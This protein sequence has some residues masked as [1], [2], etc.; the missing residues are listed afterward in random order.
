M[1][2]DSRLVTE[3]FL[4]LNFSPKTGITAGTNDLLSMDCDQIQARYNVSVLGITTTGR[5]CPSQ[6]QISALIQITPD[7]R[8]KIIFDSSG[9]M[10]STL[11]SLND[12]RSGNLKTALLPMYNNDSALYD[13]MVTVESQGIE[14]TFFMLNNNQTG[15]PSG[16]MIIIIFQNEAASLYH[17][18]FVPDPPFSL[19]LSQISGLRSSL[20]S[21]AADYYRGIVFQVSPGVFFSNNEDVFKPFLQAVKSN[22]GGYAGTN[23]LADKPEIAFEYDVLPGISYA[24]D[25]TYYLNKILTTLINLGYNV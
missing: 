25:P 14:Q 5:R 3:N 6:N 15:W 1:A 22:S 9:S 11:P 23:G 2:G 17:S 20:N 4:R 18:Y 16:K 7:T 8:I 21:F 24:S 19:Y 10:S 13:S 12:M